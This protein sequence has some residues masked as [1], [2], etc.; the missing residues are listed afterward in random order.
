MARASSCTSAAELGAGASGRNSGV[1]QH[2]MEAALVPL[3]EETVEHYRDLADDWGFPLPGLSC[4]VLMLAADG[5][6]LIERARRA[7]RD[8]PRAA[9]GA[10]GPR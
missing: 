5:E 8:V 2:P 1:V 6:D 7:A 4:G 10:A 3:Y 9:A